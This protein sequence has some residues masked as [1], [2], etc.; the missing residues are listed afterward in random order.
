MKLWNVLSVSA[1]S[2]VLSSICSPQGIPEVHNATTAVIRAFETHD[3][4]MFGEIHGNKQEYEWLRSLVATTEFARR[5]TIE[6]VPA[7]FVF[8]EDEVP[9][10]HRPEAASG[11]A[12]P[13]L[14]P[15]PKNM[16]APLPP[17]PP[18]K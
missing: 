12:R 16:G 11:N 3:I 2:I 13:A 18:S 8:D 9:E 7:N 15:P 14:G 4:V 17:R 5:L 10:F 6:G 1:A